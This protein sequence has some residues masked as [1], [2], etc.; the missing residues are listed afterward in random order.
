MKRKIIPLSAF[1][2]ISRLASNG[3]GKRMRLLEL[4][5]IVFLPT[6]RYRGTT[7]IQHAHITLTYL[8]ELNPLNGL[9]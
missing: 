5:E 9:K 3:T 1:A 7:L 8:P 2:I 6:S 4:T